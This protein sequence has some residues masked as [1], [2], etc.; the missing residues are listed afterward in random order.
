M[1]RLIK[2]V[3]SENPDVFTCHSVFS[4]ITNQS[5]KSININAYTKQPQYKVFYNDRLISIIINEEDLDIVDS[6]PQYLELFHNK[7]KIKAI[8]ISDEE[9][10]PIKKFNNGEYVSATGII[11]FAKSLT[12]PKDILVNNQVFAKRKRQSPINPLGNF[13]Q[14]E[15]DRTFEY[16]ENKI[17]IDIRN[18]QIDSR[19]FRFEMLSYKNFEK[20]KQVFS[21]S[22]N[23]KISLHN[24]FSFYIVGYIKEDSKINSLEY[25]SIGRK[26]SYGFG[27]IKI[28]KI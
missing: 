22:N 11:S 21:K 16:L 12:I 26:R 15:R 23:N 27:N 7:G 25:T 5:L 10:K 17:G 14:G 8:L 6:L 28:T 1:L 18:E 20:N 2:Y 13:N 24:V 19:D 4:K 3:C 9:Y